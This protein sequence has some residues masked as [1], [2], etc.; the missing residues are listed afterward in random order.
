LESEYVSHVF[1]STDDPAISDVARE[2]GAEVIDR[3]EALA[4]DD[5]SSESALLHALKLIV[6]T[7]A[8]PDRVIFLQATCPIRTGKDIDHALAWFDQKQA[9]SL[10]S[11]SP[12]HAILWE[13]QDGMAI[14]V[15][16]DPYKRMRRQD[17][18]AQF[19]ENGSIYVLKPSVLRTFNSRFGE[20]TVLFKMREED[21]LDI[22]SEA[23]LE[24]AE[25]A[26]IN[27]RLSH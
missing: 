24:R 2:F 20:R 8:E 23:D 14:P 3:P 18:E 17:M 19:R 10:L 25:R 12:S 7:H 21:G 27:R 13:E 26:L 22:D 6:S 16:H 15:A 5:S 4:R 1:V 11:V 9:D